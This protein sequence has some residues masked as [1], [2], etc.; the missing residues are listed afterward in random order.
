MWTKNGNHGKPGNFT[1]IELLIVI[2][3]IA[4][5]AGMLLP[6]LNQ[7]RLRAKAVQCLSQLKQIGLASAIYSDENSGYLVPALMTPPGVPWWMLLSPHI[8]QTDSS[9]TDFAARKLK[10]FG[11]PAQKGSDGRYFSTKNSY[12]NYSYN[13]WAGYLQSATSGFCL[14]VVK[15]RF[16]SQR[17]QAGD[18]KAEPGQVDKNDEPSYNYIYGLRGGGFSA[19][20]ENIP[21]KIHAQTVNFLFLDGHSSPTL[22]SDI[23]SININACDW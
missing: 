12:T 19:T 1:L 18:G 21:K 7:A 8:K 9:V 6:A 10:I 23:K 2:A 11:C 5:L 13:A 20:K 14:K 4:I 3:I 16:L 17:I 15:I 22:W